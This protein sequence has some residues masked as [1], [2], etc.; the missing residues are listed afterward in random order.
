[1]PTS[2]LVRIGFASTF[3]LGLTPGHAGAP[4][5]PSLSQPAMVAPWQGPHGGVPA[6][7]KIQP[8]AFPAAFEFGMKEQRKAIQQITDNAKPATF[9]NTILAMEKSSAMLD[10]VGILFGVHAST[11]NT[12]VISKIEQEMAPKLAAFSDE[13][14][15]N[16]PLFKRI[17]AV[18]LNGAKAKL[19]PEQR[20]L[21]WL[22]YTNFVRAGAKLDAQQKAKLGGL[23]QRLASLATQFS[24]NLLADETGP[25][26]LIE[27]EAGLAGLS[28]DLKGAAARAAEKR[29][30]KG[31]WVINNTRSAADPF[32]SYAENRDLRE[33]VWRTYVSRGDNG[34]TTDN[35]G[36]AA[37]MLKLRFERAQLLGYATHAHWAVEQSMAATPDRAVALMEAVWKPCAAQVRTDVANMQALVEPSG[38]F[39]IAPW[40]YRFYA[41][42]VRK[43]KYDLNLDE[44]MPYLQLDKL[45]E[46]MFWSA[47]ELYGLRFTRIS[48]VE[49]QHPDVT[50]YEVTNAK[51]AHVGL[52]YFDP[53]AR[54]GKRSGAWMNEYRTQNRMDQA[55]TPIVSNNSN[56]V[57]GAPGQPVLISWDDARTLF[58]EFGHALHGLLSNS[59]YRSLCGTSTATDFVEFPSQ[60]NEH[61][62][63]TPEVLNRFALHY[64]TG[65]PIPQSLLDKIKKAGTFNEGFHTMEYL[66]SAVIDMKLHLAGGKPID[67]SAFEREELAKLG[68]PSEIVMRHRI[69]QFGHIF[70]GAVGG[71][72]AGYYA[73]LWSDSL[74]ADAWEAFLEGQ[75]PWDKAVAER[76]RKEVLS[77][78]NT[79]DPGAAFRAFRGRDVNTDALMRKRGF[80][81]P[82]TAKAGQEK[83]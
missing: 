83:H 64:Q 43:A 80:L 4:V 57:K 6:W 19:T 24:Q 25:Y 59:T 42:K 35:K 49:V 79:K 5:P 68:M 16:G 37:E 21:T 15:Q 56:F 54:E 13:I 31:K 71:Y 18:H 46:G 9:A 39:K 2:V 45:R 75:G 65:Q 61:W 3:L 66:A 82:L 70:S 72:D 28:E 10:R 17:E 58:H 69:P 1:M 26:T 76:F 36:I 52:W 40:D 62:F 53:F 48:T 41:E 50:V 67:V 14:T 7:S 11:L 77:V 23:N 81:A 30:L 22:Y 20:R 27:T 29:G 34:G 55:V 12:G 32:L 44:V 51:G 47:G 74:T 38:A 33:K 73:Y 78:G 63:P 60:I 8:E